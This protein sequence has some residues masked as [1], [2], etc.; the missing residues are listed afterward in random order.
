M[1]LTTITGL[2]AVVLFASCSSGEKKVM[3][4]TRSGSTVD[5][6]SK[7]ITATNA[8]GSESKEI[9]LTD[10]DKVT[11]QVK[12]DGKETPIE[13][14]T[15][16][17]YFLNATKDTIVGSYA[18][19]SAPRTTRDTIWQETIKRSIDSLTQL[20]EG[21]NVSAANRNFFVLPFTAVK[22]SD[23]AKAIVVAP[24]HQMTSV[25]KEEGKDP[26]VYRF[27][28]VTEIREKI[29]KQTEATIAKPK[30]EEGGGVGNGKKKN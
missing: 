7:T 8:S 18:A 1:K 14:P 12:N 20:I 30:T 25:T 13:I 4:L 10:A 6:S 9:L 27:Y 23:N 3:V 16:G 5:E 17:A 15:N 22:V 29:A 21:K 26:E 28:T 19:Y 11:L 2:F 24:F